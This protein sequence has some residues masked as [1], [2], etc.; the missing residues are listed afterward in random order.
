MVDDDQELCAL[1]REFLT[2]EG[3]K[4]QAEADGP[5]GLR[6]ILEHTFDLVVL[7][8]MLPRLNGL[9]VLRQARRRSDVPVI[10][11][12]A[13]GGHDDRIHGF[14]AG[15]DDYLPK[16]FAP[17]ELLAR[18]RAVLRRTEG[19]LTRQ[20][21]E[22]RTGS[23]RVVPAARQA[24]RDDQLLELTGTE[25]DILELLVR[26]VG[27]VVTREEIFGVLYQRESSPFERAVDVHIHHLRKKLGADG[28]RVQ[29][30]RG[31]G[32]QF[33]TT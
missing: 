16:P 18:I 20:R 21:A 15:A 13:R 32:Y 19:G 28:D 7:D 25:F 2:R 31:V 12:T 10:L 24:W 29:T 14:E 6:R 5:S 33:R 26:S 22:L 27:R 9:E 3:F 17:A 11:L 23:V 8:V 4:L 30:I 1:V